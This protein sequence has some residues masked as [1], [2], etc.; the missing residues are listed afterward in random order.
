MVQ[1][2]H[3]FNLEAKPNLSGE[4]LIFFNL[5]YGYREFNPKSNNFKYIPFRIS[6]KWTIRKE[7]W[8]GRPLYRSNNTY[9]RKFGKD[10]NNNLDKI[11]RVAYDQLSNFRNI[12]EKEPSP[13]ELK[14]L[15]LEKLDR[16]PKISNDVIITHYIEAQV[17]KRTTI[18]ITSTKRWS[19]TTGN[20]YTNLVKHIKKYET[21]KNIV[22]TFGK[23]TGD[24]FMDFFIVINEIN[25]KEK[26]ELYAH[27]TISKENKHFRAILNCASEDEIEIGFNYKKK[28]YLIRKRDVE[29]ELFLT[30]AQLSTVIK[31][32]VSHSKELT[33]AKNY[34]I[35]SSFT[36]LRISDMVCL[37]EIKPDIQTHNSKQYYCF[38]TRIR[39]S[40][41]NKEEL[42]TTIPL[43]KPVKDLIKLSNNV[44]PKFPSQTNIRKDIT[45]L[46]KHL[47][48]ENIIDVK[49]Y[50]YTIDNV[51]ITKEK[52]SD[53]FTP[54]D[55]RSTFVSNLKDLGIHDEDIE[56]ITHPKHKY[57][58]IIQ[59]YDKTTMLSKAV[60][61]IT[62]L[63]SKK[64]PLFKY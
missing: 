20:Q 7:Y 14:R 40:Q 16:I 27:N 45:K 49:K 5:T 56:P 12:N 9:V 19:K 21:N 26:G 39:K 29:N 52:L 28:E 1:P 11:E 6:T 25:K 38:T 43:L 54:H 31:T 42:I 23:L 60:N 17:T 2:K 53:I 10:L 32:D 44:F 18:N 3:F 62:V 64:S 58:S 37:N 41:E 36:G 57:T 4:H 15:V 34:L 8:N 24:I 33:H 50:Y 46:L 13:N 47:K 55:C 48:F 51:V 30:S 35:L 63:N 61:L 22:L 59:V